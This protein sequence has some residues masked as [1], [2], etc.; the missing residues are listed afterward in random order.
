M[1]FYDRLDGGQAQSLT[2]RLGGDRWLE[3]PRQD[4]RA[5]PTTRIGYLQKRALHG[6]AGRSLV[7]FTLTDPRRNADLATIRHRLRRI[8]NQVEQDLVNL[9]G[10]GLDVARIARQL[11]RQ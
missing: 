8:S 6:N 11:T 5:D 2:A 4:V 9:R 7:R 1:A 10:I 3:Q